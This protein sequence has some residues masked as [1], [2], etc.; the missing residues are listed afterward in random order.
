MEKIKTETEWYDNP[1]LLTSIILG[2]ALAIIIMSQAFAVNNNLSA[3]AMLRSLL[4]HNSTYIAALIYFIL[5]K[6]KV[7]RTNFS[8]VNIIYIILYLL[9]TIASIFTVLQ[10]FGLPAII[11]LILNILVLTYMIYTFLP[12]TRLWKD[13]NLEKLP[14]DEIK[15]DWYFYSISV[16]SL[17]LLIVNLISTTNFDG[18]V[19]TLFDTIYIILF[20]RYVYLYKKYCENKTVKITHNSENH[21]TTVENDTTSKAKDTKETNDDSQNLKEKDNTKNNKKQTKNIKKKKDEENG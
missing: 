21:Q 7:G 2:V 6:T 13:L 1:N 12:E 15:N 19:L 17:I 4:N 11:S 3:I 20:S 18:I 10:S 5:L 14:F 8:L 9:I 16:I